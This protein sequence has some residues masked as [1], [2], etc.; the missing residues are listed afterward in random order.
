MKSRPSDLDL[1]WNALGKI[2]RETLRRELK[3]LCRF[4]AGE[5]LEVG[6]GRARNRER[7]FFANRFARWLTVDI[8][9]LSDPDAVG[10]ALALPFGGESFDTVVCSQMLE[11]LP[12]PLDAL[13]EI[14]RVMRRGGRLV[15]S[16]PQTWAL[17]MEPN[18]F[19]RFTR[20]GLEAMLKRAGFV[21]E[22]M[23][24]CG[25]FFATLGLILAQGAF[26]L[27]LHAR[28]SRTRRFWRRRGIAWIN[29][30]FLRLERRWGQL[31]EGNVINWAVLARR[32]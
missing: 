9:P 24:P 22:A 18:D 11:H 12:A 30:F 19:Y 16:A 8:D 4:E 2:S 31:G 32:P 21:I 15:L 20:H 6:A 26:H 28:H 13:F 14:H 1:S 25:H 7:G 3:E 10:S 27:G 17:H 5:V 29:R 23:R